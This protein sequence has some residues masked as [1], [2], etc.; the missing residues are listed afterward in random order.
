MPRRKPQLIVADDDRTIRRLLTLQAKGIGFEVVT[1]EDGNQAISS[2]TQNT[3]VVV[4]DLKMPGMSGFDCL[5]V[6]AKEFPSI[7]AVVLTAADG[8]AEA[9]KAMK[10]GAF[11]YLTKPFDPEELQAALLKAKRYGEANRENEE[12]REELGGARL[13]VTMI[14]ES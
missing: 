8:A 3:S 6:I 13:Q 1:A 10:L 5:E 2:I 4:L 11:D 9:V 14:G 12:L 7:P